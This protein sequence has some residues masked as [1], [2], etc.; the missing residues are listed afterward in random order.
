MF[1]FILWSALAAAAA[2]ACIAWPL[3]RPTAA[4]GARDL[5]TAIVAGALVIACAGGLY[6]MFSHWHWRGTPAAPEVSIAPLQDAANAHPDD[7]NAWLELGQ[8]YLRIEQWALAQRSYQRADRVAGGQSAAA[9]CGIGQAIVGQSGGQVGDAAL[10]LFNRALALDP[11]SPQ[12]LFYTGVSLMQAGELAQA[13]TRFAALRDL[14]PPAQIVDILDK[15]IAAID[16]ELA[17][18]KPDAATLI[19]LQL[20]LAPALSA[21]VPQGASLFVFVRSPAGGPP[22]AVRRLEARFPQEL[23]LSAADAVIPTQRVQPGQQVKVLARLTASGQ[24]TGSPGDLYGEVQARAGREKA[25]LALV[26]DRVQ[27]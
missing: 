15:Q 22:L 6:P 17:A 12:A 8:A 1:A 4:D 10:S 16:V 24:P 7:A 3:L 25:P 13:R 2:T 9:L 14:A 23:E 11:R 21:R 19:R 27:P 20:A 26:V 18:R 5:R